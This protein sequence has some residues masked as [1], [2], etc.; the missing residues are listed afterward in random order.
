[1]LWNTMLLALREIKRN[2]LR[3]FLTILGI[4]IGVGAV[5]TMVTIGG[6]ATLQVKQQIAQSKSVAQAQNDQKMLARITA[7]SDEKGPVADAH[8]DIAKGDFDKAVKDLA[9]AVDKFDKMS[10]EEKK[11]AAEQMKNLAKG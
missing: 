3:S 4:V 11:K 2:V 7:P 1:M 10:D 8:R 9:Q 6:G 5:I